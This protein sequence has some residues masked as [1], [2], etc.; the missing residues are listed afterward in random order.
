M[1]SCLDRRIRNSEP[2]PMQR[3][4][5]IDCV[6]AEPTLLPFNGQIYHGC[7]FVRATSDRHGNRC[8]ALNLAAAGTL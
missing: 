4:V 8:R 6:A 5:P 3:V 1:S 7:R 2:I